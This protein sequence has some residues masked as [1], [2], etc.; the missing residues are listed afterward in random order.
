[1]YK[2]QRTN[3]NKLIEKYCTGNINIYLLYYFFIYITETCR[4]KDDDDALL[5]L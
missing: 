2:G 5:L 3:K 1:M 4:Y